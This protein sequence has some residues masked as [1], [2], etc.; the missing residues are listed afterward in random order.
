MPRSHAAA[1]AAAR[2]AARTRAIRASRYAEVRPRRPTEVVDAEREEAG[3]PSLRQMR[4]GMPPRAKA[5]ASATHVDA[6]SGAPMV[7]SEEAED[8]F[9]ILTR[10]PVAPGTELFIE[11]VREAVRTPA[12]VREAA[13]IGA[14]PG[15]YYISVTF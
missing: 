7:A 5:R 9:A 6:L 15:Y 3:V 14:A 10:A 11:R 4:R 13:R 2:R 8:L 12:T 1:S